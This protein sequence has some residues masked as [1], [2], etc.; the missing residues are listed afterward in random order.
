METLFTAAIGGLNYG[1]EAADLALAYEG[2]K[3]GKFLSENMKTKRKAGKGPFKP[4][5]KIK[6]P[7]KL[8]KKVRKTKQST[9]YKGRFQK[10]KKLVKDIKAKANAL[11]WLR[12]W[13]WSGTVTDPDCVYL[14]HSNYFKDEFLKTI[15]GSLIRLLFK[16]CGID[17]SNQEQELPLNLPNQ[18]QFNSTNAWIVTF[19]V[20]DPITQLQSVSDFTIGE[21]Q[22]LRGVIDGVV[23]Q[24]GHMANFFDSYLQNGTFNQPYML[25]MYRDIDGLGRVALGSLTLENVMLEV[26][27]NSA[28]T[29]Q[30]S[31]L[32]AGSSGDA[33][34]NRVDNQPVK[35]SLFQFSNADPRL[36]Q[37]QAGNTGVPTSNDWIHG[38]GFQRGAVA[39]GQAVAFPN[40]NI[41]SEPPTPKMWK[42]CK[43]SSGVVLD[44]GMIKKATLSN[45]Y[46]NY[47]PELLKKFRSDVYGT[48][49]TQ[50]VYSMVK[51][52]QSQLLALEERIRTPS[53]NVITINWEYEVRNYCI[54][55]QKKLKNSNVRGHFGQGTLPPLALT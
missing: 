18:S 4:G 36:K 7:M 20:K 48:I 31:T 51:G 37:S 42:N 39:Y 28:L 9:S 23:A 27:M 24:P 33:D 35:G 17:V 16:E 32:G 55:Y 5:K 15:T 47:L 6:G 50:P 12:T 52:G 3:A 30:N 41:D 11:G 34:A 29:V 38:S 26:E 44:P 14:Q 53:T 46:K 54:A 25:V 19:V 45:R 1:L 49:S 21:N 43:K 13:E 2:Y 22:T 10:P 8:G 40:Y